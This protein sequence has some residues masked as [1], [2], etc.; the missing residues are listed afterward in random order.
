MASA[1]ILNAPV[2]TYAA[3]PD[4]I[5]ATPTTDMIKSI[6]AIW[7]ETIVLAGSEIGSLAAFARRKG[8]TWFVAVMNGVNP[9]EIKIPLKFLKAGSY[10][11][12][13]YR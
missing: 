11:A 2:L 13:S 1:A 4:S 8:N 10:K 3:N 5:F 6:P 12:S 7:D 9:Q